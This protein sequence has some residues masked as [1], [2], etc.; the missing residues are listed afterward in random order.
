MINS[1]ESQICNNHFSLIN[2]WFISRTYRA[3]D[4]GLYMGHSSVSQGS[5]WII[6]TMVKSESIR[7][8][9]S[10]IKVFFIRKEYVHILSKMKSIQL[11]SGNDSLYINHNWRDSSLSAISKLKQVLLQHIFGDWF[12]VSHASYLKTIKDM[13]KIR[14]NMIIQ[15]VIFD[16]FVMTCYLCGINN[17]IYSPLFKEGGWKPGDF[18]FLY[19]NPSGFHPAKRGKLHSPPPLPKGGFSLNSSPLSF[20]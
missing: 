6:S 14:I 20:W 11:L 12:S 2:C 1:Q 7:I 5:I 3:L 17:C 18:T 15:I 19:L 16:V 4:C 10:G 13:I 8:H 9:A